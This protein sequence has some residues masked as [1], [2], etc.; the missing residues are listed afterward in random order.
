MV[1]HS[2][3]GPKRRATQVLSSADTATGRDVGPGDAD[4]VSNTVPPA[5]P[6]VAWTRTVSRSGE[7]AAEPA[8]IDIGSAAI[9]PVQ[10]P[11]A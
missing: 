2:L 11:H 3:H 7:C 1:G 6:T 10:R 9:S 5:G 8:A 4:N